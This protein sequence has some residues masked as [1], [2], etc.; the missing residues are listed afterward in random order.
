MSMR[1]EGGGQAVKQER[2]SVTQWQFHNA[3]HTAH[4]RLAPNFTLE[5]PRFRGQSC[6]SHR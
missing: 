6:A 1:V 5:L 2:R 4:L 3:E